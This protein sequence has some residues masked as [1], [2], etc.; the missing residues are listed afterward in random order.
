MFRPD[1]NST[2]M[3]RCEMQYRSLVFFR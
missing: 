3:V 1:S 2:A